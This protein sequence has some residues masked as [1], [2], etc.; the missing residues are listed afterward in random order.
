[1]A[2]EENPAK[3]PITARAPKNHQTSVASPISPVNRA[4][5]KLDRSSDSLRPCLSAIRPQIGAAK[6]ATKEVDPVMTPDQI[7]TPSIVSTPSC[8]SISGMIGL[9]KLID[10]VMMN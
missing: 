8:G 2:E 5:A 9:R 10:A 6:A 4:I 7:P 1:M 3:A